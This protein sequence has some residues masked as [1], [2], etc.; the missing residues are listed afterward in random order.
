MACIFAPRRSAYD[1]PRVSLNAVVTVVSRS[2]VRLHPRI[3]GGQG[4]RQ[5]DLV[6][7]LPGPLPGTKP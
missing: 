1:T 3:Q 4:P 7:F 2:K 5:S 6:S